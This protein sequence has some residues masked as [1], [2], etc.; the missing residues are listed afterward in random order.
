MFC[1]PQSRYFIVHLGSPAEA[2]CLNCEAKRHPLLSAVGGWGCVRTSWTQCT[3]C[4]AA[5]CSWRSAGNEGLAYS[6]Q[7]AAD[8]LCW[9]LYFCFALVI[10]LTS[11]NLYH[12]SP[13]FH[14]SSTGSSR[15]QLFETHYEGHLTTQ[16]PWSRAVGTV[17]EV[18]ML[19]GGRAMDCMEYMTLVSFSRATAW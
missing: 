12:H 18:G 13:S 3:V 1:K 11:R 14:S 4:N 9:H 17:P 2:R 15:K 16:E 8:I 10:A 7:A 5:R 6:W 19:L